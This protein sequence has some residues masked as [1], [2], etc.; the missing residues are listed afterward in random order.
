VFLLL[1]FQTLLDQDWRCTLQ[2][3]ADVRGGLSVT[4]VLR[5]RCECFVNMLFL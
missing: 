2:I 4:R 1:V 3:D 5:L